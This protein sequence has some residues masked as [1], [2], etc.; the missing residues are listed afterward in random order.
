MSG[1]VVLLI[2]QMVSPDSIKRSIAQVTRSDLPPNVECWADTPHYDIR[3][4]RSHALPVLF[5]ATHASGLCEF[6]QLQIIGD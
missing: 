1:S 6:H 2:S 4:F 5:R 3:V